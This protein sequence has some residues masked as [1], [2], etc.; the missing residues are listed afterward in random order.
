MDLLDDVLQQA[1][2]RRRL[3]DLRRFGPGEALRFPCE[4]SLGFHVV[5]AGEVV[6]HPAAPG[7]PQRLAAGDLAL[8]ARGQHHA[9]A[10]LEVLPAGELPVIGRAAPD[11]TRDL[12]PGETVPAT[13]LD[14]IAR[15]APPAEAVVVSGA[16]QLWTPPLHPLF[17]ALPDWRIVRAGEQAADAPLARVLALLAQEVAAPGPGSAGVVQGL[18]DAAFGL[19]LRGLLAA[20]GPAAPGWCRVVGAPPLRRALEAMH[21]APARDWTLETLARAAGMSRSAFA[22]KFREALGDTPLGYLR[23]LRMQHAMRLLG[24]GERSLEQV[25]G[26]VGY[27]DAFSFSKVFK[28]AVG[29]AP[30]AFRA[31]DRAER[32]SPWRF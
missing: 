25:A 6:L 11:R 5:L 4:R 9:L 20:D 8:M 17:D 30:R 15:H 16:W 7:T 24:D 23:T 26:D 13:G 19:L 2:V 14:A 12:T 31:A 21:A 10:T 22:A 18:L 3:L 27:S 29:V 32:G 1:G 28:R